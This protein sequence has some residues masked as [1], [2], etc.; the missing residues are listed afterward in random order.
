MT[1]A[2]RGLMVPVALFSAGLG[3]VG[4]ALLSQAAQAEGNDR[5]EGLATLARVMT[6]VEARHISS[7]APREL[8]SSA[9]RGM[10]SDLDPHSSW[11][12]ASQWQ[13][14]QESTEGRWSG[15]GLVTGLDGEFDVVKR[16]IDGGPA[17]LAGLQ[18]GDR[19]LRVDGQPLVGLDDEG[20]GELLRGER[21]QPV[22]IEF[23]RGDQALE[24]TVVRDQV[25]APSVELA[26]MDERFAYAHI[27]QFQRRSAAELLHGLSRLEREGGPVEGLLLDLRDNP[28]GLMDEAIELVDLFIGE[29]DIVQTRDRSGEVVEAHRGRAQVT[30]RAIRLVV[31]ING[32]SA[33]A[34]EVV[35]GA[36]QDLERARVVGTPSF[37]K[38]SVQM[39]SVFEDGSALR[40]T[41]ARYHLPSGRVLEPGEGVIPDLLVP[42]DGGPEQARARLEALAASL[43]PDQADQTRQDLAMLLAPE[44]TLPEP[45]IDWDQPVDERLNTDPQLQAAWQLLRRRN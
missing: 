20:L 40:L 25:F 39:V 3:M 1:P 17:A 22:R 4:G 16:T 35:A 12:E 15:I 2:A 44:G 27:A 30:D 7:P 21:G 13:Q 14:L 26:R 41:V 43:P 29:G 10:V 6:Q 42:L 34:A 8:I 28:G 36:L 18:R 31:L 37:G 38:G 33:S 19:L 9:I 23:L 32:S 24:R 11:M 5:Y 45:V